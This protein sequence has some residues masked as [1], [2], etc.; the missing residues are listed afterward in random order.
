MECL[1]REW[2]YPP[3]GSTP[4]GKDNVLEDNES[5]CRIVI[6]GNNPNMRYMSRTQRI[7][8]SWLNERF[9]DG[10]F[11]FFACP[12]HY[13]GADIST[14]ACIDKVVWNRNLHTLGMFL[15]G[16]LQEYLTQP[17]Q[18]CLKLPAATGLPPCKIRFQSARREVTL[19]V[20][21]NRD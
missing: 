1:R 20:R 15:A 12:S 13:Q 6:T 17:T 21:G 2:R 18:P 8:I 5:A 19:R 10:I 9:N 3:S 4:L 7:D 11:R 16:Y 14:K